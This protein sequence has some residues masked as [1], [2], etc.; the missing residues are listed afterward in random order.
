M[1][2]TLLSIALGGALM[3]ASPAWAVERPAAAQAPAQGAAQSGPATR[4]IVHYQESALV[5]SPAQWGLMS[6]QQRGEAMK[7]RTEALSRNLGQSLR[8]LRAMGLPQRHVMAAGRALSAQD[9]EAMMDQMRANDPNILS[10][11]VDQLLRP[12]ATPTDPRYGD[13]WHY[14][15]STAGM[16][17]PAAWDNA[18]GAGTVVAVLDTGYRPHADLTANLLPGYDMIDDTF[19]S[20]DGDGRDS[21]AQDPGDAMTRGECGG[22]YPPSDYDS[23]WHGT[24]VAGTVA[25]TANNG[26]GVVGVAYDA[27]VV[28]V[29]VLGKC[30]GYTSDIADGIVWASG[31]S[32]SGVPGNAN[33]A[34]VINMSLGGSGSCSSTTQ[35]AIDTARANGTAVVVAAGNSDADASGFNPANCNGVITVAALGRDGARAYYS[36]YGATVD[37]SAPGGAQSF[38]GDPNGV[39]STHNSGVTTPGSDSYE[40]MQ[41]TSM[42]APHVAGL[43]AMMYEAD[44]TM[45]PDRAESLLKSTSRADNCSNCGAGLVDSDA[46][47]TAAIN[48]DTGGGGEGTTE[49]YENLDGARRSW[50][51]FSVDVPAGAGSLTVSLSGGSGDADLYVRYGSNPT[52]NSYDCRP[53]LNGNNETCS[54][55]NPTAGTWYIGIYGYR[56]YS[57]ATLTVTVD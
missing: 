53:Y 34:D 19:V 20:V 25:A 56:A 27:K 32:V 43:V 41:G 52:R 55:A 30:G 57:G 37:I 33:P 22:G 28:P 38:A 1:K 49:T 44:P 5:S 3:A 40:F 7:A 15:E 10:I 17:L 8:Y 54:G 35:A 26:L 23:S 13:Q 29:R 4:F 50:Q 21:D 12:M 14:F 2:P 9:A 24:H 11:E 18:T 51:Y 39:L 48:G 46:A 6:A 31:G 16:N 36:N 47:V 45:T 42:A